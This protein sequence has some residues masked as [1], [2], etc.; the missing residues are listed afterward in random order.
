LSKERI[1][2]KKAKELIKMRHY[3]L[4]EKEEKD[5]ILQY[6]VKDPATGDKIVIWCMLSSEAVGIRYIESLEKSMNLKDA[7]RGI[8]ITQGVSTHAAN[9]GSKKRNIEIIPKAFP[10][11]HLFDHILVPKHEI[12]KGEERDNLLKEFR[13]KPYQLP[14]IKSSDPAARAIGARPGD[15]V[16]V[17][18]DSPTAGKYVSYRYVVEG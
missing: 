17:I 6:L 16:K 3:K 11:F 10:S 18:R 2:I 4:L 8:V 12:L 7:K 13:V 15:I 1:E 14:K 9:V 5:D